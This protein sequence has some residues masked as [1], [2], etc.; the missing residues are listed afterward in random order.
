MCVQACPTRTLRLRTV[1][2][3]AELVHMTSSH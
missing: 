1:D 2:G 3:L